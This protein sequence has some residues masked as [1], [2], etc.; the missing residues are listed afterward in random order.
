MDGVSE[1]FSGL[2]PQRRDERE[3]TRRSRKGH[4]RS[5]RLILVSG[6]VAAFG[7]FLLGLVVFFAPAPYLGMSHAALAAS[8]DESSARGCKPAG[9]GWSCWRSVNGTAH[10]YRVTADWAGCW[11]GKL[12]GRRSQS[13]P[14]D[15]LISGCVT[16][17]DH[18][19]A[20]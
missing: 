20:E 17:M 14:A 15:P 4:T 1:D 3:K 18:L 8:V 9:R 10:R 6:V 2:P 12:A 7:L 19:R 11:T 5:Y 16:V 13:S